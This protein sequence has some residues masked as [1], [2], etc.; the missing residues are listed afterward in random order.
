MARVSMQVT[1]LAH[2]C[3]PTLSRAGSQLQEVRAVEVMFSFSEG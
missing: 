2:D 3:F 1:L